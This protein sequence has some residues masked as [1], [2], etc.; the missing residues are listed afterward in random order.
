M[1]NTALGAAVGAKE[2]GFA[3]VGVVP[4]TIARA[5]DEK[6]QKLGV[7]LIK[8]AGGGSDLLRRA[9]EV[10]RER[11]GYFVHPHLDPRWTDGYQTIAEEILHQ[12]PA[13]R[14]LVFPL[15]GGGLLMGLTEYLARHGSPLCLLGCEPLNYSKYARSA[16]LKSR[17]I[18]DGLLLEN[19]HPGVQ[20]RIEETRIEVALVPEEGIRAALRGLYVRHALIIEP[21]S[22][23]ALAGVP[24]GWMGWRIRFASSS[25]AQHRSRGFRLLDRLR[26]SVSEDHGC[27][28]GCQRSIF[29]E[30]IRQLGP[31]CVR[32]DF[33]SGRHRSRDRSR[34]VGRAREAQAGQ[35]RSGS[36]SPSG[37]EGR[38]A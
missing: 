3:M 25:R 33:G 27:Y 32:G 23:V 17:S 36:S 22:A 35:A 16:P 12:L 34:P 15:G 26:R 6:L 8:I 9:T 30:W 5:K 29:H 11:N 38:P 20:Q 13:C 28:N 7:E 18:A 2:L 24:P 31:P 21:S 10:A 4:E 14:S 37:P 1:G 19:P